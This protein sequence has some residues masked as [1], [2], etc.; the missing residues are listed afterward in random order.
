MDIIRLSER[1]LELLPC[2]APE[3]QYS[4]TKNLIHGFLSFD[5]QYEENGKRLV[6]KY[7]IEIDLNKTIDGLPVVRE[8]ANQI[9]GIAIRKNMRLIDL[10]IND[11]NEM[12]LLIPPKI[13]EKYPDGFDL[14]TLLEH[15]QEHLYYISF[16]EKY[17]KEPWKAYA[18]GDEGYLELY[19]E[20]K[21]KYSEVFKEHF[22]C[23][24]RPDLRRKLK[25]L[26]KVYRK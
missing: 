3:L 20:D 13:K 12:C 5:L 26:R 1:D 16:F 24:S 22:N 14:K 2:I 25:E 4:T 21:N 23:T 7:K 10:H 11:N 18:H 6:D 8:T 15:I 17:N 9:K 19:L